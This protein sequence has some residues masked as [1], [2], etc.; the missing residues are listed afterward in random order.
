[1]PPNVSNVIPEVF[2]VA[3]QKPTGKPGEFDAVLSTVTESAKPEAAAPEYEVK[4]PA[5]LAA[6]AALVV[7]VMPLVTIAAE[8]VKATEE[9]ALAEALVAQ[10]QLTVDAGSENGG[11]EL[12][13]ESNSLTTKAEPKQKPTDADSPVEADTLLEAAP[14]PGP[15]PEAFSTLLAASQ[16][17]NE[18]A[19]RNGK[20]GEASKAESLNIRPAAGQ[21]R[22]D[23]PA[24]T[25]VEINVQAENRPP[26]PPQ[27]TEVK[28]E[29]ADQPS[30]AARLP[31]PVQ[32]VAMAIRQLSAEGGQE[33]R[34]QLHPES[35]GRVEVRLAY[36]GNEVRVHVTTETAPTG[37]LIRKHQNDLR[38]ALSEAGVAVGQ[39]SVSVG[40]GQQQDR[41]HLF[42]ELARRPTVIAP[43]AAPV[44]AATPTDRKS[45]RLDLRV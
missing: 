6:L 2:V 37:A 14:D 15:Q 11:D 44:A 9:S 4:D 40:N 41:R 21:G 25:K 10:Q 38:V 19:N 29:S 1:M 13:S 16:K 45:S 5:A 24:P 23:F 26:A 17:G 7:P 32:R 28:I 42:D 22:D 18:D 33:V 3:P 34:L 20:E 35:L 27:P 43:A 39:L 12:L 30:T 8:T 31:E 36:S